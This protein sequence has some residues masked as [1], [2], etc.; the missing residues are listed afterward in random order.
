MGDNL[1]TAEAA[2]RP[3]ATAAALRPASLLFAEA[4]A[5]ADRMTPPPCYAEF[6][7]LME[8]A[9]ANAG[10]NNN[11]TNEPGGTSTVACHGQYHTLRRCLRRHGLD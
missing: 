10:T 7:R 6:L 8:C 9:A 11:N 2:L 3:A 1:A 5:T 4:V